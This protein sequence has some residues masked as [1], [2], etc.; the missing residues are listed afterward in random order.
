[1]TAGALNLALDPR[2]DE[3]LAVFRLEVARP[4]PDAKLEVALKGVTSLPGLASHTMFE[5]VLPIACIRIAILKGRRALALQLPK[6]VEI[7]LLAHDDSL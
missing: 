3:A 6:V 1:M 4:V 2:A 7:A 5:A